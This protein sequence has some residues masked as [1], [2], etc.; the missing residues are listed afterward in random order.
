MGSAG[1]A[2]A[3]SASASTA[4]KPDVTWVK[5]K[6]ASGAFVGWDT[7]V[8]AQTAC[9]NRGLAL[10]TQDELAAG[11]VRRNHTRVPLS[12]NIPYILI[13]F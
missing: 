2:N 5:R 10:C 12:M 8:D 11:K 7:R 1:V 13:A 4:T 3:A 9:Y 6:L